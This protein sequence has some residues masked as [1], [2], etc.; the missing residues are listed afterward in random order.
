[1]PDPQQEYVRKS[2][3]ELRAQFW[4]DERVVAAF[5]E[6]VD[7]RGDDECWLWTAYKMRYG[8]GRIQVW[9]EGGRFIEAAHRLSYRLHVGEIPEGMFLDHLCRTP[10]CVNPSHLEPV[11]NAE[12]VM[13]GRSPQAENA[14]KTRCKYGHP[15][16]GDNLIWR[17]CG[18]RECRI[19]RRRHNRK[20]QKN[21]TGKAVAE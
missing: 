6:R 13:R 12:N 8:H 16:A 18:R 1:M 7:R 21:R 5:W 4:N 11:T 2:P 14:R 10:A 20:N 9:V 15:L 19:C 3:A 17:A